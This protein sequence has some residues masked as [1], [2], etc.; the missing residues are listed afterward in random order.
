MSNQV[1]SL[2][3]DLQTKTATF[4]TGLADAA[5]NA[6][7]SF[8]EIK[9][10]AAEMGRSTSG[11]MGEARH[12]VMLLGE[13]F[14]IH[15]PRGVTAFVSSLGPVAGAM[16]AAFPF[17]AIAVGAKILLDHLEKVEASG[18]KVSAAWRKVGDIGAD[19]LEHMQGKLTA[20]Q[21]RADELAGNH[22]GALEKKL[23]E[24][25]HVTMT[26]LVDEMHKVG[27]AADEAFKGSE[28]SWF[29]RML[30][31]HADLSPAKA[32][33]AG[34]FAE[35]DK[36]K[37]SN[38]KP[39]D[40]NALIG[41][42]I[43]KVKG[44]MSGYWNQM[45]QY[46]KEYDDAVASGDS[47]T[48]QGANIALQKAQELWNVTQNVLD[49]LQN[50]KKTAEAGTQAAH[51]EKGNESFTPVHNAT[52]PRIAEALRKRLA[53]YLEMNEKE[54]ESDAQQAALLLNATQ[55]VTASL[56]KEYAKRTEQEH[57][58]AEHANE[59]AA[60]NAAA[61]G[62]MS[63]IQLGAS[64][65][66]LSKLQEQAKLREI[67]QREQSDLQAAH[68]REMAEQESY[69]AKMNQLAANSSGE[70]QIK[71]KEQAAQAQDRLT[72][73]VREYNLEMA[74]TSAAI[75][76]SDQ[77]TAKLNNSWSSFF[78]KANQ[79][80]LALAS[81]IRGQLQTSMQT[82]TD[83]FGKGIARSLVEGKNFGKE[84]VA[85]GREMSESLIEGLIRWGVQD[86]ITKAGMKATASSLAGANAVASMAAAPFPVDL[87]APG[88]GASMM[89][90]A[91]A[92]ERG[93]LV[94]GNGPGD[95]VPAML[96]PGEAVLPKQMTENLTHAA[97][98]GN[99]SGSGNGGGFHYNPTI[100]IHAIDANGVDKM[101]N[102]H[103]D[104]F[105]RH[106]HDH[107][108]KL[109]N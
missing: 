21:I 61:Q 94:P 86:L 82:A 48:A 17:L 105:K 23:Q 12:G 41:G 75:Q 1:W 7:S 91:M 55:A 36:L 96:T 42:D 80:T 69:I 67:L 65:Y 19:A 54:Q 95:T 106:F 28:H 8:S 35:I 63:Q 31:G 85:A 20:A 72:A 79:D 58:A 29:M 104:T 71:A 90:V 18:A 49:T 30:Q 59:E 89:G 102:E 45:A 77:E 5:R 81:M 62:K 78:A 10:G 22:L 101:L 32:Q 50:A 26:E 25:D 73:S 40:V 16:E 24:I 98:H 70:T 76:L 99:G 74:R 2:S 4:S 11:S 66:V 38:A 103:A 64:A 46:R 15:L 44:Q 100:H 34:F 9:A 52:D 37:H 92:F 109:N 84:M 88:F 56:Q 33:L 93:G 27:A 57:Q 13:E 6:R 51:L 83:A 14:G 47:V 68:Q 87:G 3:V 108:R 60:K 107:V 39:D 43:D 97:R 53:A